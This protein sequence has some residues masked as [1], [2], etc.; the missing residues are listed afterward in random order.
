M[1]A[2]FSEPIIIH[3]TADKITITHGS[4]VTTISPGKGRLPFRRVLVK[5]EDGTINSS[6]KVLTETWFITIE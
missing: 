6:P 4:S 3:G 5:N 1:A 2:D